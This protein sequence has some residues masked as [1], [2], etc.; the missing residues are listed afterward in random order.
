MV[1]FFDR[2]YSDLKS[3][4]LILIFLASGL[5]SCKTNNSNSNTCKQITSSE[6][7]EAPTYILA[8]GQEIALFNFI[9]DVNQFADPECGV[10]TYGKT[11][12]SITNTTSQPESFNYLINV[13]VG[14]VNWQYQSVVQIPANST[15]NVGA[16]NSTN[17]QRIH[18]G[19]I[20]IQILN[21]Q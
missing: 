16:I 13:A 1:R 17:Q 18:I 15:V 20:T 2:T 14:L 8:T 19:T 12:L 3:G 10:D 7:T 9:Q 11:T 5:I 6:T 21:F 4:Y